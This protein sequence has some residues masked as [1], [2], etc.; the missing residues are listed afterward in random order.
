MPGSQTITNPNNAHVTVS[1][2]TSGKDDSG[3]DL[4]YGQRVEAFV[5]SAAIEKGQVVKLDAMTTTTGLTCSP[6]VAVTDPAIEVV[7]IAKHAAASGDVVDVVVA[8]YALAQ[9][10]GSVTAD[11]ALSHDANS[12]VTTQALDATDVVGTIVGRALAADGAAGDLFPVWVMR[13]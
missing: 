13:L 12:R 7:G 10:D 8:G 11:S 5:A 4:A 2:Y 9:G 3:G 6:A 1:D